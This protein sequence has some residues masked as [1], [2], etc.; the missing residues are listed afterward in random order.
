MSV[1]EMKKAIKEK[2]E[3]LNE[4]RLKELDSFI[5]MISNVPVGEWDLDDH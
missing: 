4:S 3:T 1:A 2:I 5:S